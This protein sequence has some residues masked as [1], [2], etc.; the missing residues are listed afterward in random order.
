MKLDFLGQARRD[1]NVADAISVW[2]PPGIKVNKLEEITASS[3]LLKQKKKSSKRNQNPS[4]YYPCIGSR[5][6]QKRKRKKEGS[7]HFES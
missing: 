4:R 5:Q 3:N 7:T 1:Q 6:V 2:Y